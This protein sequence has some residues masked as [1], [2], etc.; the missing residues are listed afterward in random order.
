MWN[1][2]GWR[3]CPPAIENI[4]R[5]LMKLSAQEGLPVDTEHCRSAESSCRIWFLTATRTDSVWH[6]ISSKCMHG[7]PPNHV[8]DSREHGP[9]PSGHQSR[10][11]MHDGQRVKY[12]FQCQ[13]QCTQNIQETQPQSWLVKRRD[14]A[15]QCTCDLSMQA[16]I[17]TCNITT[18]HTQC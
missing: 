11:S 9:R 5:L 8:T 1:T 13:M 10:I 12:A 17:Q 7:Y 16:N 4:H 14:D 18:W 2:I 15:Q 3:K 6:G